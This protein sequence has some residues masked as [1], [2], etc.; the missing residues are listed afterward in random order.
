MKLPKTNNCPN[1]GNNTFGALAGDGTPYA[2]LTSATKEQNGIF[3][4]DVTKVLGLFPII[5]DKCNY[6]MLFRETN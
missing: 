2:I 3:K 4:P 6:I 1:C 5:C